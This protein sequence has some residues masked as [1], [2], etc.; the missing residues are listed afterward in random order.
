MEQP[1]RRRNPLVDIDGFPACP[2][3]EQLADGGF[4]A[5]GHADQDDV[6]RLPAQQLVRMRSFSLSGMDFSKKRSS[7]TLAWA[8]SMG[9]PSAAGDAQGLGLQQQCGAAGI[10]DDVQHP[11]APGKDSQIHRRAAVVRDT[12]PP[13]WR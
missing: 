9:S 11:L 13:G 4:A 5:A 3:R 6:L 12:C 10:V 8:T 1:A 2:F 7:A